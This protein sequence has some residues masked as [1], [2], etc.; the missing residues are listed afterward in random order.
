MALNKHTSIGLN[1]YQNIPFSDDENEILKRLAKV[2]EQTY[3]RF[4][5]LQ[6]AE[7]QAREAQIEVSLERVRA[8][9]MA[10]HSS[11]KL[12]E[13]MLSTGPLGK[14]TA[15]AGRERL[16]RVAPVNRILLFSTIAMLVLSL[17][18]TLFSP[19]IP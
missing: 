11:D 12:R 16:T 14:W 15:P 13:V 9:T 18:T 6:K 10:M 7:E 3:T 4:L 2:F 17:L 8:K 1:N 19:V 5:D